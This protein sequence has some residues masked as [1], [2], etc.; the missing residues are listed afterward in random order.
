MKSDT[1]YDYVEYTDELHYRARRLVGVILFQ[2]YLT[3]SERSVLLLTILGWSLEEIAAD[4]GYSSSRASSLRRSGW[5]KICDANPDF[6]YDVG[7]EKVRGK[8]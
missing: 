2:R 5:K 7:W 4:Y 6:N 3:P 8:S 1:T